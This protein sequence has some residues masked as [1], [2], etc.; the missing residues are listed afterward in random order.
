MTRLLPVLISAVRFMPGVRRI[1]LPSMLML[2]WLK[3]IVAGK[4]DLVALHHPRTGGAA[5]FL[6]S[7]LNLRL[8]QAVTYKVRESVA[9][10]TRSNGL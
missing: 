8:H 9:A 4:L 5:A 2:F 7:F 3:E 10:K 6:Y 1:C